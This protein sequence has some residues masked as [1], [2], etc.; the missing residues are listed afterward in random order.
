MEG[1]GGEERERMGWEGNKK[2]GSGEDTG[3][4]M[5]EEEKQRFNV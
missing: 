5:L 1:R 4:S 2:W 3:S